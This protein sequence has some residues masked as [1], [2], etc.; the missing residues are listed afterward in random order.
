MKSRSALARDGRIVDNSALSI[1]YSCSGRRFEDNDPVEFKCRIRQSTFSAIAHVEDP[2]IAN[3]L[4]HSIFDLARLISIFESEP[5][6]DR[7]RYKMK[8]PTHCFVTVS[9]VEKAY[10]FFKDHCDHVE[11]ALMAHDGGN[12]AVTTNSG[13]NIDIAQI[14]DLT[15]AGIRFAGAH[16]WSEIVVRNAVKST[17]VF[18]PFGFRGYDR[19]VAAGENVKIHLYK[20]LHDIC[21]T[22]KGVT[23]GTCIFVSP[24]TVG[25][26]NR[27]KT[28]EMFKIMREAAAASGHNIVTMFGQTPAFTEPCVTMGSAPRMTPDEAYS[29]HLIKQ[30]LVAL[31]EYVAG[32]IHHDLFVVFPKPIDRTKFY[33]YKKRMDPE[34]AREVLRSVGM[35]RRN[36]PQ[37]RGDG[38]RFAHTSK[39][40]GRFGYG[41][42][43]GPDNHRGKRPRGRWIF[44]PY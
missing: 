22:L 2:V 42:H 32:H 6:L 35:T 3:L 7:K 36:F 9:G 17:L 43:R 8:N 19:I 40:D 1:F 23:G 31:Q 29:V 10:A 20:S 11:R 12:V 25:P 44:K 33:K 5:D 16:S 27:N 14:N 15:N 41:H 34:Q 26:R 18:L 24:T 21:E 13:W 30:F 38:N 39:G 37:E 28:I 4:F